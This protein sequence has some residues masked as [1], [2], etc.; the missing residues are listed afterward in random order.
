MIQHKN[1][2]QRR[3]IVNIFCTLAVCFCEISERKFGILQKLYYICKQL[4]WRCGTIGSL[5]FG[6]RSTNFFHVR[7]LMVIK[8]I[9]I[10]V[11]T[12][13]QPYDIII[14]LSCERFNIRTVINKKTDS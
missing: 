12:S 6:C 1:R 2:Y 3:R 13:N 8:H 9:S 10:L 4:V 11:F 5:S 7:E 14:S